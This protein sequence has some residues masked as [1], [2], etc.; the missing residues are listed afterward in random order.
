MPHIENPDFDQGDAGWTLQPAEEGSISVAHAI[1]LGILQTR[2]RGGNE[3]AGDNF[4]MTRRSAKGPNRFSQ[5][6]KKLTPGRQYSVKMFTADY[7]EMKR[8]NPPRPS[9]TSASG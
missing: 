7:D 6:I 2:C 5:T 4:L 3:Q 9:T 8:A 1:G